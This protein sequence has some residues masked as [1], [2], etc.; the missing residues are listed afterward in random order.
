VLTTQ[1]DDPRLDPEIAG[2]TRRAL[3]RLQDSGMVLSARSA[4]PLD[5]LND[6]LTPILLVEAWQV[7]GERV[8]SDPQHYGAA[9]LRLLQE[10]GRTEPAAA[11]A[12]RVRR[13]ELLSAAD[14]LLDGVDVLVGPATPYPAPTDTPPIDTPQ[15]AVEGIFTGP[16]NVTGQPAIVIA[17]G[18]TAEGLPVA[19]QLAAPLGGDAALL[20]VA[21]AV[22]AVL[23]S[24]V[25]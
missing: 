15:G 4:A 20:Q 19:L 9:T 10:A 5:A 12:A 16:Y 1:L 21:A 6:C 24:P 2:I 3:D 8:R 18:T 7:H 17:C 22:E 23:A 14:A 11:D 25:P 13:A